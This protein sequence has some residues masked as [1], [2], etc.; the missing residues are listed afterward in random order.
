MKRVYIFYVTVG[1]ITA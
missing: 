1:K